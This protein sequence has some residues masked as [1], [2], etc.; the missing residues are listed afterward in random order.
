[1]CYR[2]RMERVTAFKTSD[3]KLFLTE[4]EARKNEHSAAVAKAAYALAESIR[5]PYAD[6]DDVAK[7]LINERRLVMRLADAFRAEEDSAK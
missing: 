3:G 4:K 6:G 5:E 7:E 2:D 1:M